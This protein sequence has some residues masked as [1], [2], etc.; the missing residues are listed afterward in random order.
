M[1]HTDTIKGETLELLKKLE[2]EP[3]L[4]G[5]ALAGGTALTLYLGHRK[6]IDLD[7]FT[8]EPFDTMEVQNLLGS[9]F[10]FQTDF[11]TQNTLKGEINGMKID[12]I[13]HAYNQ[14]QPTLS[15]EGIR[16][17]DMSDIAAMKLSA[18]ADNGTRLKDFIDIAYLSTRFSLAEMLIFY[19]QK[20]PLSNAIRPLKAITYF[21]DIDF[22]ESIMML[23]NRFTWESIERR[24]NEMVAHPEKKFPSL[25]PNP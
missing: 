18:I 20:Y 6:S 14:L 2:G 8:T 10:G 4:S 9:Q 3:L 22:D 24:L 12:C 1:L 17:Y 5:F 7:L 16:L 13:T 21:A 11:M 25:I 23:T 15:E 19:C